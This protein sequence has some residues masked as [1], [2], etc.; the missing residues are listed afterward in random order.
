M[1]AKDFP[2]CVEDAALRVQDTAVVLSDWIDNVGFGCF[3]EY[4]GGTRRQNSFGGG[5]RMRFKV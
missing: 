3:K 5:R 4:W 1:K 2:A